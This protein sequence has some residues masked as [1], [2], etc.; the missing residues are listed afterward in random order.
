MKKIKLFLFFFVFCLSLNIFA[1]EKS[2]LDP[3]IVNFEPG[4]FEVADKEME[5]MLNKLDKSKRYKI[6]G[7][8][9]KDDK[10]V[11]DEGRIGVAARRAE[12]IAKILVD[13]GFDSENI[14]TVVYD[15]G[16]ECKAEII[17]N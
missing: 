12:A 13:H 17:E 11:S 1:E 9:C 4:T 8:A 3:V 5:A 16:M 6:E 2:K 14:T 15:E 7:C 10:E